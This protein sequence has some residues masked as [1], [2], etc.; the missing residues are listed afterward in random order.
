MD[1][2]ILGV[3]ERDN[4]FRSRILHASLASCRPAVDIRGKLESGQNSGSAV[5]LAMLGAQ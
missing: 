3:I 1:V 5:C 2:A 4:L